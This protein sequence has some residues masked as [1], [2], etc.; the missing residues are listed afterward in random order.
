MKNSLVHEESKA[1][2]SNK[3]KEISNER[4][5]EKSGLNSSV[6]MSNQLKN[7]D[8]FDNLPSESAKG[9]N[10]REESEK[11]MSKFEDFE[12]SFRSMQKSDLNLTLRSNMSK[13]SAVRFPHQINFVINLHSEDSG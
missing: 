6:A 5:S 10:N 9:E 4:K 8:D 11:M 2:A 13:D 7:F 3:V 12:Q 1:S